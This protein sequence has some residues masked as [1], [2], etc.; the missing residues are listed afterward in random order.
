MC[1]KK[2]YASSLNAIKNNKFNA[3]MVGKKKYE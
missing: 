1:S 2:N 3:D